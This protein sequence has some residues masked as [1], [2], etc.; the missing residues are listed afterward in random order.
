MP[1]EAPRRFELIPL[2]AGLLGSLL[3]TAVY[4]GIVTLAE[5]PEHALQL[6]WQDRIYVVPI[7]LGFGI[8][9][10][11]FARLRLGPRVHMAAAGAS[12][13]A[14]GGMSTAAMVA[15]CLHHAADVLPV[16][17]LSAAAAFLAQWKAPFMIVGLLTNVAGILGMLRA[18]RR[19]QRHA[20]SRPAM[21]EASV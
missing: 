3:L 7:L 19:V 16:L 2:A 21:A 18:L 5:S 10:G 1:G 13:A 8:Q 14:G 4:L 11:L 20:E 17:G 9:S 12:T 15:C 6:F